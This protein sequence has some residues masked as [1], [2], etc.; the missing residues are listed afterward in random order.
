MKVHARGEEVVILVIVSVGRSSIAVVV[1]L[2][3]V[4]RRESLQHALHFIFI[5]EAH[6][7][8]FLS[9]AGLEGA[10]KGGFERLQSVAT[11]VGAAVGLL[12]VVVTAA[13]VLRALEERRVGVIA[14]V[15]ITIRTNYIIKSCKQIFQLLV[16]INSR[17]YS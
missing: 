15:L 9:G 4:R 16:L 7:E 5:F 3:G 17:L 14:G 8:R 6:K 10:Q 13:V 11:V 2:G 1:M 12:I